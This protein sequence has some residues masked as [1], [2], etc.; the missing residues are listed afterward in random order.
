[1]KRTYDGNKIS[2]KICDM[3]NVEYLQKFIYTEIM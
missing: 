2:T 3:N 1:M